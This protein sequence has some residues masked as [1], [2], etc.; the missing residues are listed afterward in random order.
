MIERLRYIEHST[1]SYLSILKSRHYTQSE[2]SSSISAMAPATWEFPSLTK[3]VHR[4]SY[5]AIDPTQPANSAAGKVVL[6]T[7]GG[8]G[9]GKGISK[10]FV[11]AGAK[12]VAILGRRENILSETKKELESLGSS[13]ILTLR[14]DVLD[15]AALNAAFSA[16]AKEVGT[17]DVV[18]ANVGY[19]ATPAPAA[20]TDVADWWKSF[21]V[22]IKGTLLTFRAFLP[23][24]AASNAVF[25]S[26]NT[27]AAH[28]GFFPNYSD[29]GASKLGEAHLIGNLQAEHP[30]L[31]IVS[32]HPGVIES[33]MFNKSAMPFTLDDMSLPSSFAVWLASPAADWTGGRF[34]WSNWDVEE[35]VEMKAE[36][37]EKNELV[38]GLVGWPKHPQPVVA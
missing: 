12:A 17:I 18:V 26:L 16:T 21:E 9:V 11:A 38:I 34:L 7:G 27:G 2:D 6:V 23:H 24:R 15:E 28:A 1:I 14:A 10:A 29:Y 13:K 33:E 31:R 3:T 25:I 30:E 19:M 35:L 37:Q 5:P 22:N 36:I 8:I 20:S 32:M 4:S